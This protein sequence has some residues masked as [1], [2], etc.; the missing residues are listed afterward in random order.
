MMQRLAGMDV[1]VRVVDD[2]SFSEAA[3]S[4]GQTPSA[5]S[6]QISALEDRLS[7]RLFSR[8]TRRLMLTEAGRTLLDKARPIL[9]AMNEA[10]GSVTALSDAPRGVL[11]INIPIAF[12]EAHIA[13]I[14][15]GFLARYPEIRLLV[16]Q[17]DR[18]VD[19]VE[20]GIDVAVRVAELKDS[21]LIARRL[22]PMRRIVCA[23]P[24]YLEKH[25][26][27]TKP[28]ELSNHNCLSFIEKTHQMDW[29]F[30]SAATQQSV[31]VSGSLSANATETL[32]HA[33]LAGVG[34]VRLSNYVVMRDL[35]AGDL[36]RLLVD[37][38]VQE[39][40][41]YAVFPA[42][43]HLSPKTRAFV[44]YLVETVGRP[45]YWRESGLEE[46]D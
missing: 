35:R 13:P 29:R 44:D 40:S 33:A 43:R 28:E 1:F 2:G 27:P 5:I 16:G 22:A 20:E 9:E 34:I 17:S 31:A 21:S 7:T 39:S 14:L 6:K 19:L 15:P 11:K 24:S 36:V 26:R 25:G 8:T 41:V 10:E 37:Y 23:A 18:F 46:D 42:S 3:R 45:S 12:G 30:G 32:R 38:E 4:L